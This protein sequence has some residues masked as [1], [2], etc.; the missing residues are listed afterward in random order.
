M[1]QQL[2]RLRGVSAREAFTS[3][4]LPDGAIKV[5]RR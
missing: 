1:Q 2:D 3:T 5:T 4:P